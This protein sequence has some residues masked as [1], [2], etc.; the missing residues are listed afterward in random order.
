MQ[1][2]AAPWLAQ[3]GAGKCVPTPYGTTSYALAFR[4]SSFYSVSYDRDLKEVVLRFKVRDLSPEALEV[5]L[6]RAQFEVAALLVAE[7]DF[8]SVRVETNRPDGSGAVGVEIAVTPVD[9]IGDPE[10]ESA[11]DWRAHTRRSSDG[12]DTW[13]E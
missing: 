10:E 3:G 5:R 6:R 11:V 8:D 2:R 4:L 7:L 13:T 12:G 1:N 9:H